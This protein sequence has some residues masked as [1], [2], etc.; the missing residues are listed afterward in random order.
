MNRSNIKIISE[1]SLT[2]EFSQKELEE[3]LSDFT[4]S[5]FDDPVWDFSEYNSY[6]NSY[7]GQK[8]CFYDFKDFPEIESELKIWLI[9]LLIE[10]RSPFNLTPYLH[11]FKRLVKLKNFNKQSLFEI[12]QND[13]F[14]LF[15]DLLGDNTKFLTLQMINIY[16]FTKMKIIVYLIIL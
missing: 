10:G 3:T 11:P 9:G 4:P 15:Q 7:H 5:S 14:N 2:A 16:L 13:I 8:L 1:S 6:K 12:S